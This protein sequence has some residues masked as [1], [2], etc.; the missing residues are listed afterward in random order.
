MIGA[1]SPGHVLALETSASAAAF[2]EYRSFRSLL[3]HRINTPS[4]RFALQTGNITRFLSPP[5][6]PPLSSPAKK[7]LIKKRTLL[8]NNQQKI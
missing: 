2:D 8:S 1:H 4:Q 7:T 5:P 6:S 3:V